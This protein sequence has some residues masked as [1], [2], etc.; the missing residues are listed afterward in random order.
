MIFRGLS[1]CSFKATAGSVV[2]DS[3]MNTICGGENMALLP[4]LHLSAMRKFIAKATLQ[5]RPLLR[6]T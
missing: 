1:L 4:N 6:G 2:N 5:Q 3:H